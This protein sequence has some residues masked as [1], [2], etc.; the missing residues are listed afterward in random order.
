MHS[1]DPWELSLD[2]YEEED[3][4]TKY[5]KCND[6]GGEECADGVVLTLLQ[7]LLICRV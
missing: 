3:L 6:Q 1:L 7:L 2:D 4:S 5:R